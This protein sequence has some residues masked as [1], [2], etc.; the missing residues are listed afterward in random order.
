MSA[1]KQQRNDQRDRGEATMTNKLLLAAIV[2]GLWA[3]AVTSFIRPVQAQSDA[4]TRELGN[5]SSS[6]QRIE[7]ALNSLLDGKCSN[8]KICP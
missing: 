4:V 8:E 3:N 6:V 2:V 7:F 1:P 5:I